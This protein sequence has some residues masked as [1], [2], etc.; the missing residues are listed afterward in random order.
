MHIQKHLKQKIILFLCLSLLFSMASTTASTSTPAA[1]PEFTEITVTLGSIT[2]TVIATGSLRFDHVESLLAPES[3]TL[4]SIEVEQGDEVKS[5]QIL[6]HYDTQ[7]LEETIE[8]VEATLTAQDETILTLL[9]QQKPNQNIKPVIEGV[10]K[11]INI[12]SG[13]MVQQTLQDAPLA[14]LSTNGL[15][16]VSIVP[17]ATLSLG[18]EVRVKVGTVSYTGTV[19]RLL[20]DGNVLI[21][22]SDAKALI[23]E[24]V[25]VTL[26]SVVIGEGQ[27]QINQPYYLYTDIDGVVSSVPVKVN[28]SVT[29]N[30]VLVKVANAD[31]SLEYQEALKEREEI[32]QR[33]N[34]LHTLLNN[35]VFLSPTA[36][37]VSEVIAQT[38]LPLTE[39]DIVLNL[40][41]NQAFVMDVSVDEL[42]ILSVQKGQEGTVALDALTDITLPV[43]VEKVSKLGSPSSGITN[44]TVTLSVAED[45][46]LLSGMNGTMTLTVGE[47]TG[48]VLVPLAALMSDRQGS[49]VL[50]KDQNLDAN[51]EQTGIK[52]YV[53]LGLSDANYAAV[54]SGLKEGDVLLVRTSALMQTGGDQRQQM[55]D[56]GQMGFPGGMGDMPPGGGNFQPPS[57]G[58][59]P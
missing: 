10:L 52:T 1:V 29:R 44:Y 6:A 30:T 3:I 5:G 14:I 47:E 38:N 8:E 36:G 28:T 4:S 31:P 53:K 19:A 24:T 11:A 54:T 2:K 59:R 49:Y 46:R 26:N 17:T 32:V 33:L 50:L 16:Q 20:S 40:Y 18:Q 51:Q 9:G 42:D 45:K 35:P 12:E 55:P 22:F 56:F 15:M 23:D 34:K 57:G 58:Q 43:K 48:A 21:T 13:Q 41:P 7:A 39:K 27:A 37:I 25:Q